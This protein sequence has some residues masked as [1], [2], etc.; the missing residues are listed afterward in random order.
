MTGYSLLFQ[1]YFFPFYFSSNEYLHIDYTYNNNQQ[2]TTGFSFFLQ[3]FVSFL[4]FLAI[5]YR[6]RA[7]MMI[8][9]G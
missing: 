5:I 1:W 4:F 9:D 2:Q 8:T 3:R 6:L 7:Q